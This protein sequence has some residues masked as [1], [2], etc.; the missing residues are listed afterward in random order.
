M[1]GD[2]LDAVALDRLDLAARARLRGADRPHHLGNV[3][4]GDVSV[5]KADTG[6]ALGQGHGQVHRD[7]ALAD[8]AL[9]GGDGHNVTN[10]GEEALLGRGG[11]ATDLRAP[12]E[13][14]HCYTDPIEGGAD[15]TLNDVLQGAGG[16]GE[17]DHEAGLVAVQGDLLDHLQ[18][19]NVATELGLLDAG[20]G[21]EDGCFSG[22]HGS[23]FAPIGAF[24]G[25]PRAH[26]PHPTRNGV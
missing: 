21:L 4:P 16:G 14:G 19:N 25:A 23:P 26:L 24:G 8:A 10:A 13:L 22:G 9:P 6:A 1:N 15:I 17:L 12:A 5:E 2:D 18:C 7:G 20:E 3:R 11:G